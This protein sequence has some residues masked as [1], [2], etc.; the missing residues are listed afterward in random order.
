MFVD[1]LGVGVVQAR[2]KGGSYFSAVLRAKKYSAA[3]EQLRS[4]MAHCHRR[5]TSFAATSN[6]CQHLPHQGRRL[7]DG[8]VTAVNEQ[9]ALDG[10]ARRGSEDN[11]RLSWC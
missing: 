6:P 7:K 4:S 8:D 5:S 3:L 11:V 1:G 10:V 9:H 2:K